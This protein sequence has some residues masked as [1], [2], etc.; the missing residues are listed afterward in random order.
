MKKI[1]IGTLKVM[2]QI[3]KSTITALKFAVIFIYFYLVI[4]LLIKINNHS[5]TAHRMK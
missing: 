1:L 5:L 3:N 2:K 4:K